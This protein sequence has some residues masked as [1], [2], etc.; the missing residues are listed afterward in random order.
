MAELAV[1]LGAGFSK[2]AGLPLANEISNF[3]TRD[4]AETILKF[5]SGEFMW[6]D[7]ASDSYKKNGVLSYDHLAYGI[8]LNEFVKQ[9]T[10]K[11][12]GFGN[13]EDFYQYVIDN[14]D[15]KETI[16]TIKSESIKSFDAHFPHVKNGQFYKNYTLAISLFQPKEFKSLIIH[17][18]GDL[19][20]V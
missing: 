18:I 8:L 16:E 9:H 4:N 20:F 15:N 3:F 10:L 13:Y 14:L 6:I 12:N 1:L 11:N 2:P 7:F 17:L 5:S 19:L